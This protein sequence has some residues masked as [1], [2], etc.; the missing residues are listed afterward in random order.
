[1]H[2]ADDALKSEGSTGSYS[3]LPLDTWNSQTCMENKK[4]SCFAHQ[5]LRST[6]DRHETSCHHELWNKLPKREVSDCPTRFCSNTG[7]L[8][9]PWLLSCLEWLM[10]ALL[11]T[12]NCFAIE[13][14]ASLAV[15][16]THGHKIFL[17]H[18][19]DGVMCLS[20]SVL[21]HKKGYKETAI[22]IFPRQ[23]V[24]MCTSFFQAAISPFLGTKVLLFTFIMVPLPLVPHQPD[25]H[26][27]RANSLKTDTAL[28]FQ[29]ILE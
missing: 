9:V 14:L 22:F 29:L 12:E 24:F 23:M 18:I 19:Y 5:G 6:R 1:M 15:S 2:Q 13:F 8:I 4:P 28:L 11:S 3:Q 17:Y 10:T 21:C 20:P 27:V 26:H 25:W 7:R 16:R